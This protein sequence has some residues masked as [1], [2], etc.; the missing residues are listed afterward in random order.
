MFQK[1]AKQG[2]AG[3]QN[4][5]GMFYLEGYGVKQDYKKAF[6]WLEKASNQGYKTAHYQLGFI[7]FKGY[8]VKQNYK[9]AKELFGKACNGGL[10]DG[11]DSYKKLNERGY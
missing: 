5:L 11:C 1:S 3:G 6:E 9:K 10:Q 2:E 4:E 8:G 7:Y